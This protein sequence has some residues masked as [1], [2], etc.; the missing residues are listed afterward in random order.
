MFTALLLL[1]CAH[2]PAEGEAEEPA[3]AVTTELDEDQDAVADA[4]EKE[5]EARSEHSEHAEQIDEK[6]GASTGAPPRPTKPEPACT[7]GARVA[8]SLSAAASAG[9]DRLKV[10]ITLDEG[11]AVP[12]LLQE[13][14]A[15][16]QL[17]QGWV[18]AERLCD[19]AAAAGVQSIREPIEARPK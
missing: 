12:E 14:L 2:S 19:L 5:A 13:P 9:G 3:V 16:G 1:A 6:P 7:G 11:A 8:S 15:A 18:A 17:V 4:E 10:D